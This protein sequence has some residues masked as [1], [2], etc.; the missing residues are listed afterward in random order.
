MPYSIC[1]DIEND[2]VRLKV[3]HKLIACGFMRL[4]KS[5][6]A[7]DP[8]E[9]TLQ[10]LIKWLKNLESKQTKTTFTIMIISVTDLQLDQAIHIGSPPDKWDDLVNPQNTLII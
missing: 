2:K 1:Y 4:Q 7:G 9:S 8:R 3:A 6:F 5:V 10:N